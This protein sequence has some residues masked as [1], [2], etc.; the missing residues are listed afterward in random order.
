MGNIDDKFLKQGKV[1]AEGIVLWSDADLRCRQLKNA[2]KS[3]AFKHTWEITGVEG[4]YKIIR[5][6]VEPSYTPYAHR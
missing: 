3:L 2:E 1:I 6:D 4:S 5:R